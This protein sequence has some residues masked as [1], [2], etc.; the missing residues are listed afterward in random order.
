MLII[1][2][3]LETDWEEIWPIVHDILKKYVMYRLL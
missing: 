2:K 1:R 3:A